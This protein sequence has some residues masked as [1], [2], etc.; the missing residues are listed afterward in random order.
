[1]TLRLAPLAPFLSLAC[2]R[3]DVVL[4]CAADQEHAL[5]IVRDFEAETGL[6][7][8]AL[9]DV[10]ASK[11]VGLVNLL[12]EEKDRPRCD[13][14]WNNELAHTIRLRREGVLAPYA[15]PAAATI[16]EEFRD[17][18]GFWT[19]FAARARVLVVHEPSVPEPERPRR[20][21][22]LADPKWKGRTAI[23]RPITGTTL[24]HFAALFET[25][26]E[27][28]ARAFCEALLGNEVDL[29]GGNAVVARGVADGR[30]AFGLTD[31]D[32]VESQ[33]RNGKPVVAV[34]PDAEGEG[35]LLIPN[36][37]MLIRGGPHPQNGRRLVDYLLSAEVE[38][39]LA[40]SPSANIPVRAEVEAPPSVRRIDSIRRMRVDWEAIAIRLDERLE[41]LKG[42]FLR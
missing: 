14:F 38:R 37:V 24:T 20:L 26:G 6:D 10:E 1:M 17:P 3:A 30:N 5:P 42:I 33:R 15:S 35:T 8:E 25:W 22:E 21:H 29:A 32:D 27:E 7:V 18:G 34:F 13:V 16:P 36:S 40:F 31:T 28:R 19:G 4:Y 9:Y 23:A 12:L 2:S 11:T 41:E 39:R